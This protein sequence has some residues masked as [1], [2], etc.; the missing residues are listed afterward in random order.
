[1]VGRS[2][3]KENIHKC[4]RREREP[5]V[6]DIGGAWPL[7]LHSDTR[8][9]ISM[10]STGWKLEFSFKPPADLIRVKAGKWRVKVRSQ[11]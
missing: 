1:M 10:G 2:G 7:P 9:N 8:Y 3:A 5:F 4:L 11:S 6:G